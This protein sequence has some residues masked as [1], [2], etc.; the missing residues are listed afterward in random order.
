LSS[1]RFHAL[2]DAAARTVL[3]RLPSLQAGLQNA[4]QTVQSSGQFLQP[5]LQ[6]R[7]IGRGLWC[8]ILA[9]LAA[10]WVRHRK[11][12]HLQNRSSL[13]GGQ[14]DDAAL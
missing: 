6:I 2:H 9:G 3:L 5:T 12:F 8:R 10:S 11:T 4:L 13:L 14:L 1:G 7:A